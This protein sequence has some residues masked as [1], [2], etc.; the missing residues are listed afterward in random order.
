VQAAKTYKLF[1]ETNSAEIKALMAILDKRLVYFASCLATIEEYKTQDSIFSDRSRKENLELAEKY[2]SRF[3]TKTFTELPS[4]VLSDIE[5]LEKEGAKY[6]HRKQWIKPFFSRLTMA[7]FGAVALLAPMLIMTLHPTKLTAL[8]TTT[9]F[10]LVVAIILAAMMGTAEN[11]DVIAATAAYAAVLVVFVG[12]S[13]PSGNLSDG[14]IGAIVVGSVGS[15]VLLIIVM[16]I[17]VALIVRSL[18]RWWRK[19]KEEKKKEQEKHW[20]DM[21]KYRNIQDV[22]QNVQNV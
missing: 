20:K 1:N 10:V 9:I 3:Y 8:L 12:T 17:P 15:L 6:D 11:K 4:Y 22:E 14:I 7:I 16:S 18:L 13:N 2:V 21:Q 19:R 5:F